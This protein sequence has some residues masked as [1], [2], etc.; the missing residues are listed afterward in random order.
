[1]S[2]RLTVVTVARSESPDAAISSVPFALIEVT[3]PFMMRRPTSQSIDH[4]PRSGDGVWAASG[5]ARR[6]RDRAPLD[7][8]IV[9]VAWRPRTGGAVG[10]PQPAQQQRVAA[11]PGGWFVVC[12]AQRNDT[13]QLSARR[14]S[15][16][17]ATLTLEIPASGLL[18][19][20]VLLS[21]ELLWT[22][23]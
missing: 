17:A 22:K 16:A 7:S 13:I 19:H 18:Q 6:E 15:A 2:S 21:D 5:F 3:S 11:S 10:V 4:V 9:T 8:V 1:M 12:G 20:D 23:R 14:N